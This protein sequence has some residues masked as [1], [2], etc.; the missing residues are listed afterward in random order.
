M[1]ALSSTGGEFWQRNMLLEFRIQMY[2]LNHS[3]V[4]FFVCFVLFWKK[5]TTG[6]VHCTILI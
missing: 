3:L 1:C 6:F 2:S 4:L 5:M